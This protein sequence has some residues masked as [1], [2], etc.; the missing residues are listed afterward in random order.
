MASWCELPSPKT[1]QELGEYFSDY[2]RTVEANREEGVEP[3]YTSKGEWL[4][5]PSVYVPGS[6]ERRRPICKAKSFV[7]KEEE[8]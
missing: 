7:P 5:E 4:P 1:A 6:W 8:E 3:T 2:L